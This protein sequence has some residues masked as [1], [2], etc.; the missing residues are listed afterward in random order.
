[1]YY[2][3]KN[4]GIKIILLSI[5]IVATFQLLKF[6]TIEYTIYSKG[7]II[8]AKEWTLSRTTDGNFITTFKDNIKGLN[9][10]FNVTEFSRGDVVQ[11]TLSSKFIDNNKV[12]FGDTIGFVNSNEE[13]RR[14]KE[15]EDNLE[16]LKAELIFFTTGQKPEDRDISQE[17]LRLA[18]IDL[19]TEKLLFE[20][21]LRLF[22]DSVITKQEIEVLEN[23]LR[24]KEIE[25][26]IR[27]AE[28]RSAITG[29]KPEQ[30]KLI[31]SKIIQSENQIKKIQERL[32]NFIVLA[33]FDGYLIQNSFDI[34]DMMK[35]IVYEKDQMVSLV[36]ID[37]FDKKYLSFY[38]PVNIYLRSI[39][40]NLDAEILK[41]DNVI[42]RINQKQVFFIT[43]IFNTNEINHVGEISE[44]KISTEKISILEYLQRLL[45]KTIS[46]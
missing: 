25:V 31:A 41:I 28:Y 10:S 3:Y 35:I 43:A 42:H 26:L 2:K 30:E 8:P 1:M 34:P 14:L 36:P 38:N 4:L 21:S 45:Y 37:I 32:A 20:R 46:R 33:P 11:F 13:Q 16:V 18:K 15:L 19:D 6:F 9:T 27:D 39:G 22:K 23:S 17:K 7:L 29:D 12:S 5:I 24:L 40:K 44:V